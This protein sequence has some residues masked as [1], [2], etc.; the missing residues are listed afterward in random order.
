M[1]SSMKPV[2]SAVIAMAHAFW[3]HAQTAS[4]PP[5]DPIRAVIAAFDRVNLVGLG[6]RHWSL[7]DSQ[8]RLKLIRDPEFS[9]KVNDIVIEFGNPRYQAV[10]DRFV[11]G[12]DVPYADVS[13]VWLDTTQPRAW[14]SPVYAEFIS[15]VRSVNAGLLLGRR[16]RVVAGDYPIDSTPIPPINTGRQIPIINRDEA[17]AAIIRREVL[18]KNRKALVIF[19]ARHLYRNDPQRLVYLLNEDVR[20]K[21]FVV[22]P[23]SAAAFPDAIARQAATSGKPVLL[24]ATGTVGDL[25]AADLGWTEKSHTTSVRQ[26]ADA[27]LYFGSVWPLLLVGPSVPPR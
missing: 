14:R 22:V 7:E 4:L 23:I 13:K 5:A 26:I 17:A 8:F 19:G 9:Q 18:D 27:C 1:N 15:A 6:E 12:D 20:T 16:L 24:M 11:D 25:D 2:A 21:W 10:L 3:L